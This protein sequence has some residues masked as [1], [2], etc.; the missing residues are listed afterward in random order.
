M[1]PSFRTKLFASYII[2]YVLII[3]N[4]YVDAY[5]RKTKKFFTQR[6]K[7]VMGNNLHKF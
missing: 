5:L 7:F 4:A 6:V 1:E 2:N 3:N